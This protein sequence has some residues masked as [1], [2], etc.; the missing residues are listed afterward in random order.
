MKRLIAWANWILWRKSSCPACG[1]F[2]RWKVTKFLVAGQSG[3]VYRMSR[4][5]RCGKVFQLP[6]QERDFDDGRDEVV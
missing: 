6:H 4:C 3:P 1:K 2:S 5:D